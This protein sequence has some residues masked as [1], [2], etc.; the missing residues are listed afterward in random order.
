MCCQ[1]DLS[2]ERIPGTDDHVIRLAGTQHE[3]QSA[4]A[5]I[6]SEAMQVRDRV[7]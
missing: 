3:V 6:N 7:R 2:N 4:L 1:V 5:L